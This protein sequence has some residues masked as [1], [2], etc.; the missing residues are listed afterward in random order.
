MFDTILRRVPWVV[1]AVMVLAVTGQAALA[2]TDDGISPSAVANV[3]ADRVD[4]R[5]AVKYTSNTTARKGKLMAFACHGYLPNNIVPWAG[6]PRLP[7][8]RALEL[9]AVNEADNPVH[10]NQLHGVPPAI[11]D[12]T[13]GASSLRVDAL[14]RRHQRSVDQPSA[15]RRMTDPYRGADL[16]YR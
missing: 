5:H 16:M 9:G 8:C 7:R 1:A 11:A 12:G 13:T 2:G 4:G 3:N 15:G 6:S 10:W 14:A